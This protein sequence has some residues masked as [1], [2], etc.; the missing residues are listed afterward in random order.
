MKKK[1]YRD[2]NEHAANVHHYCNSDHL[3][4][5]LPISLCYWGDSR[6]PLVTAVRWWRGAC[7][8]TVIKDGHLERLGDRETLK[9]QPSTTLFMLYWLAHTYCVMN[10]HIHSKPTWTCPRSEK[11]RRE[12]K[13]TQ[14]YYWRSWMATRNAEFEMQDIEFESFNSP[15]IKLID[16]LHA[17]WKLKCFFLM[18]EVERGSAFVF[19]FVTSCALQI[20]WQLVFAEMSGIGSIFCPDLVWK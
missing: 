14:P 4:V 15:Q 10:T 1:A 9:N 5:H 8:L 12:N 7:G 3:L 20:Y 17:P 11:M 16:E 19:V 18:V 2:Q 6:T 13:L